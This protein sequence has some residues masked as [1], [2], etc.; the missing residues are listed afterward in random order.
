MYVYEN[1]SGVTQ[2]EVPTKDVSKVTFTNVPLNDAD[3]CKT[4]NGSRQRINDDEV[5]V[6]GFTASVPAS[7]N[8]HMLNLD[9]ATGAIYAL[10]YIDMSATPPVCKEDN[11]GSQYCSIT[12]LSTSVMTRGQR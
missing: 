1:R 7:A 8:A 5:S 12:S 3:T 2:G 4:I 10:D 6:I 9:V 11:A